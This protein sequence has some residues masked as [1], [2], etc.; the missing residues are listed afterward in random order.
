VK[1]FD[2][3]ACYG[4]LCA[5][6]LPAHAGKKLFFYLACSTRV[7]NRFETYFLYFE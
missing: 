2:L 5:G 3:M 7:G 4:G 1:Q 6:A